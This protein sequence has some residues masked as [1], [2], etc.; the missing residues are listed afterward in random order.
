M[1]DTWPCNVTHTYEIGSQRGPACDDNYKSFSDV[2]NAF[3][4]L[5]WRIINSYVEDKGPESS[6]EECVCLMGWTG[7]AEPRFPP[8]YSK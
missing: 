6:R 5:G 1:A 8:G 4:R 2:V 3:L 7:D